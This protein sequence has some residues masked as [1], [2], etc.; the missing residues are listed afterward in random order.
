M[1]III[2]G[3]GFAGLSA[4]IYSRLSGFDTE[5]YEMNEKPGGLCTTWKRKG[6][7]FDSC[8]HWLVGSNPKSYFH[9]I[10][11]EIGVTPREFV[12]AE[13]FQR[14]R[15]ANGKDFIIYSHVD[16][17]EA[18]MLEWSKEDEKFI[19]E[20]TN[21]I[22]IF[23][24]YDL[25]KTSFNKLSSLT[26]LPMFAMIN[27]YGGEAESFI[28]KIKNPEFKSA[29]E[30]AFGFGK[31]PFFIPMLMMAWQ[32]RKDG[33]YPIGGSLPM[34]EAI[35]RRYKALDGK[36][37]YS[38]KIEKI[39]T[40]NSKAVGIK[41]SDGSVH[42][43]DIIISAA[44]GYATIYKM[45]EGKFM[46]STIDGYYRNLKLFDPLVMVGIGVAKDFSKEPSMMQIQLAKPIKLEGKEMD[47]ISLKHYCKDRTFAPNGKSSLMVFLTANY[48]YWKN[49]ATDKEKYNAEKEDIA[50]QVIDAI[51]SQFP[52]TK[53]AVE[54]VDVST[55]I[56]LERY[57][58]NWQGSIEGWLFSKEFMLKGMKKTL[59][60]LS[61]FYMCGQWVEPG[62]GLPTA[63]MSGYNVIKEIC[64]A[65][66]IKFMKTKSL[67]Q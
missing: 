23:S 62:G 17:F 64:K 26:M 11:D 57:T 5:I 65:N 46:D 47:T 36:I 2:I 40:E 10:W 59:P 25:M 53:D 67:Y 19:K 29:F 6:Y 43:A 60:G 8:I 21:G 27:K 31:M 13:Q 16:K 52:G 14:I 41:L 37:Y 44:D 20:F 54:I 55:P 38:S 15:L 32:N 18:H 51:E 39:I 42:K 61:N 7:S 34:S 12:D 24:K 9:R 63:A 35:E 66:K 30:K 48:Q 3:A 28:A 56:T 4:G 45:L 50:K 58:G 49:L 33:G 22:R 1:K